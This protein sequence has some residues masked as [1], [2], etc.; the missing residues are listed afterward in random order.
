MKHILIV[1]DEADIREMLTE[2]LTRKNYRVSSVATASEAQQIADSDHPQL[3]ISDLQLEDLD[4]LEMIDQ[5]KATHPDT[6][7]I[8]LTGV[9]F[10]PHVIRTTLNRKVSA[11]LEK[12]AP[13]SQIIGEVERLI[14]RQA[15]PE[16]TTA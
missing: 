16:A 11:Y 8:L 15:P 1:D 7:V 13:L 3:I 10:D 14:G 6:P 4:G 12:T 2:V 9:L 5:L